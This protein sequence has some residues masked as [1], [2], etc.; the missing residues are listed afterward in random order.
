MT[1][2]LRDAEQ[3]CLGLPVCGQSGAK[4]RRFRTALG[5][6]TTRSRHRGLPSRR[7][8][9]CMESGTPSRDTGWAISEEN[10]EVVRR[11]NNAWNAG[12]LEAIRSVYAD[13]VVVETGITEFGRTFEGDNPIRRWVAEIRETSAEVHF[14][15]E[16]I[17]EGEA[18]DVVVSFYRAIG[19]GRPKRR[20]GRAARPHG[21]LPSSRRPDRER[22][23]LPRPRRGSRSRRAVG[24]GDYC[25]GRE[26]PWELAVRRGY[27]APPGAEVLGEEL[28][29]HC[30]FAWALSPEALC[31]LSE[32]E[33]RAFAAQ[34]DR[35]E[36][37]LAHLVD[38]REQLVDVVM[39]GV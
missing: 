33:G 12:D 39:L 8:L 27:L 16:R 17:F 7:V 13:D 37:A 23:C 3:G 10:V 19:I 18:N 11:S 38:P 22:A 24:L 35:I 2:P 21:R 28:L 29:A 32:C 14:D 9:L 6:G 5:F 31:V 34:A 4:A 20:R 25:F 1:T 36:V 15:Y 30:C 26:A